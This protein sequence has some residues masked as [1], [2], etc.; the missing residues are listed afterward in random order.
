M[1]VVVLGNALERMCIMG[2]VMERQ[3]TTCDNM[4]QPATGRGLFSQMDPSIKVH[5]DVVHGPGPL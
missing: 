5:S 3:W 1:E 4:Q 2:T